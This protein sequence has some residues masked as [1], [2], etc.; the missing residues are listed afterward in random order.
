MQK[1]APV[2]SKRF[3]PIALTATFFVVILAGVL[4]HEMWRDELHA[5]MLARDSNSLSELFLNL[6]SE[7]HPAIWHLILFA[8]SRISSDPFLMQFFHICVATT[9]VYLIARLSPFSRLQKCMLAFGYFS[10]YE[11]ALISRSYALGVLFVF[12][13]CSLVSWLDDRK[14][15]KSPYAE[16]TPF[17]ILMAMA[18]TSIYGLL[19]SMALTLYLFCPSRQIRETRRLLVRYA[20]FVLVL[21]AWLLCYLQVS[22]INQDQGVSR[23][24]F[25]EVST[26]DGY[27]TLALLMRGASTLLQIWRSY[28]PM[29]AIWNDYVWSSN[30]LL[31]NDIVIQ[32]GGQNLLDITALL[33]SVLLLSW[34]SYLLKSQH[35]TFVVFATGTILLMSFSFIFFEGSIRH[36][37]H[38]YLLLVACLWLARSELNRPISTTGNAKLQTQSSS[39][40]NTSRKTMQSTFLTILLVFHVAAGALLY[41]IDW[42]KPF[43]GSKDVAHYL[44][45]HSLED[46]PILGYRDREV[47][48]VSAYLDRPIYYPNAKRFGTFWTTRRGE[49]WTYITED[50]R[51]FVREHGTPTVI[52]LTKPMEQQIPDTTL[53]LLTYE[54]G[55]LVREESFYLYLATGQ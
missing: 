12:S 36:H 14:N 51:T 3:F 26:A 29:P 19:M 15:T 16:I 54:E 27:D 43:S 7:G 45:E 35:R 32:V 21:V 18:N 6:Q 55:S 11:Y 39:L 53:E 4:H 31:N 30:F 23:H 20:G 40:A 10:L 34:V 13:F 2:L 49:D 38:Y 37:G 24:A 44:R 22:R 50:V 41:R 47:T 33:L 5:W 48:S 46:L 25:G 52:V 17:L 42:I 1:S 8:L 28:V 9:S